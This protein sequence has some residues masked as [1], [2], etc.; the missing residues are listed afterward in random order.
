MMKTCLLT[1][2]LAGLALQAVAQSR[3]TINGTIRARG[4]GENLIR[5]SVSVV[6]TNI[7]VT[8]NEYGFF[9]L[10]LPEGAYTLLVSTVGMQEQTI[11]VDLHKNLKLDLAME[12][13]AAELKAVVVQAG[14]RDR[15]LTGTQMGADRLT[16]SNIRDLPEFLGEKD[17]L[18]SIQLL[19]G[20]ASAGDGNAGFYVRGGAPDQNLILLDGTTVYNPTHLLGFFSTFNSEAIRDVT[21]YKGAMPPAYGGR[22]SSVADIRMNEGNNQGF[23]GDAGV[24]L[25]TVNGEL[26]GPIEKGASSFLV[27]ARATRINSFLSASN[28]T[29]INRNRIGFYDLNAK[30]NFNLGGKDHLYASGYAGRDDL[31]VY[32]Q[33]GLQWGNAIGTLRWNHVFGPRLFTNT[34]VAISHYDTRLTFY[35]DGSNFAVTSNLNDVDLKQEWEWYAGPVH[36][37]RFGIQSTYHMIR[38]VS[39]VAQPGSGVNDTTYEP[40]YGLESAL[41]A[42]D[43][44]KVDSRL[45][46]SYG[47]RLT[48]F[49][50]YGPGNFYEVDATGAVTDTLHYRRGQRVANYF[51]PEP[52]LS[53]AYRLDDLSTVKA[54]YSRNVQNV[55]LLASSATA[56]PTDRWD[57]TNNTIRPELADQF[58]VGYY[59]ETIDQVFSWNLEAYYKAL[60]HQIDYRTGANVEL[61]DIVETE[62]LYGKGRAYGL[63]G[64]LK[65]NKGKLTGWVSYTLS[66]SQLQIDGI[67]NDRWYD[68]TQDRTHN[69]AVVAIYH[70]SAK[71]SLSADWV[72]YTGNAVSYPSGKYVADG[73]IA[74]YYSERNG[75]RMPA[76]HRLDLGATR[77][78]AKKRWYQ[79]ELAFGVY[80]AY[81]RL[82]AYFINFR[83]DPNDAS[84]TQ[85]LQ[86]ALF[87]IVP[88]ISYNLKF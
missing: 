15:K 37:V 39:L 19:P 32:N 82:N 25:L 55:H 60:Q 49:R 10:T 61:T 38:P 18:K 9:S 78:F 84:K 59:R 24:G 81:D 12:P 87:G 4:S 2:L 47:L 64:Q 11:P 3:Y 74:F 73:R 46:V 44:W 62:L 58:S 36:T 27:A 54:S 40:R 56:Q 28:D 50:A 5:A 75:Y 6:G 53:L 35:S 8:S 14:N 16:M 30:L 65:K 13:G 63:E 42:G 57:L 21:L 70:P 29:T 41:F 7:G 77:H 26:E 51:N 72:Y 20:V 67:N 86:T 69:I 33:F 34:S 17:V 83:Q 22:L 23:H 71:W 76:Y 88:Y 80:N 52:R 45:T 85:A 43:D 79:T 1:L 31:L 48:D 68:A 66:K